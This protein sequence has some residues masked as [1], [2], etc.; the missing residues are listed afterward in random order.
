MSFIMMVA[1]EQLRLIWVGDVETTELPAC[2]PELFFPAEQNNF[3]E[4]T[5]GNWSNGQL[6]KWQV[7]KQNKQIILKKA[8]SIALLIIQPM[9]FISFQVMVSSNDGGRGDNAYVYITKYHVD[10]DEGGKRPL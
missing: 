4:W 5:N 10:K 1:G 8:T 9:A 2:K 6:K 3:A 7:A